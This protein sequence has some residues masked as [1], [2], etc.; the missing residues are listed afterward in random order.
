MLRESG[1][2]VPPL[3]QA[4]SAPWQPSHAGT[5]VPRTKSF[6][7]LCRWEGAHHHIRCVLPNRGCAACSGTLPIVSVVHR[8]RSV[9]WVFLPPRPYCRAK[10]GLCGVHPTKALQPPPPPPGRCSSG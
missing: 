3:T 8:P 2:V 1:T 10:A 7:R 4:A 6:L 9:Q 5:G